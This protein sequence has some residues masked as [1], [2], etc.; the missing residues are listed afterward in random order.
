MSHATF[1]HSHRSIVD[2]ADGQS[3]TAEL[4]PFGINVEIDTVESVPVE[5]SFCTDDY[6][7]LRSW[8]LALV[9]IIDKQNRCVDRSLRFPK[10]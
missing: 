9:E 10:N 2:T 7:A 5:I 3:I 8:A 1:R 4:I 6:A